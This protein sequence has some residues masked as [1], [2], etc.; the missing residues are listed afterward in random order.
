MDLMHDTSRSYLPDKTRR[1]SEGQLYPLPQNDSKS[2]GTFGCR[3]NHVAKRLVLPTL[4]HGVPS[5]IP[6]GPKQQF[7]VLSLLVSAFHHRIMTEILLMDIKHQAIHPSIKPQTRKP[8][9]K[10]QTHERLKLVTF[11]CDL[12]LESA[13]LNYGF[14]TSSH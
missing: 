10:H 4:D 8:S 6:A 3:S 9:F 14:C 2:G 11:T 1:Q 7:I 12:D 13:W 5:W